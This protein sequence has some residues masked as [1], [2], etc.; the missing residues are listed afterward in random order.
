AGPAHVGM[1]SLITTLLGPEDKALV[2][3]NG[4][5]GRRLREMLDAHQVEAFSI[6]GR[7]GA[8]P[9]LRRV[10]E[11]LS[12]TYIRAVFAV[13]SETSTGMVNPIR[14]LGNLSHEYGSLFVVDAVSSLGGLPLPCDDWKVDAAFAASQ[15]CLGGPP[16]IAPV[17]IRPSIL[18]AVDSDRVRGWYTNLHTWD[19][20]SEEWGA[21]HP[22]PTTISSNIFRAFKVSLELLFEEGLERRLERHRTVGRAYREALR[23]LGFTTV[24]QEEDASDTVTAARPPEGIEASAL[25]ADLRE[26]FD[27]IVSGGL[28]ELA[29]QILRIG[30]MGP[31]ARPEDLMAVTQALSELL[32]DSGDGNT[33]KALEVATTLSENMPD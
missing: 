26:K 10:E 2:I 17:A 1:E 22:Q 25:Q 31:T 16:G 23:A 11:V 12:G 20:F 15:K 30:H 3:D 9:D 13:H 6:H 7:W 21:W 33:E 29:G 8:P 27:I 19:Q 4:F 24:P 18:E 5:F 14:E 32:K 28:T